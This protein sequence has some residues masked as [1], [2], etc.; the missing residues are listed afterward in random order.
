MAR[1][2]G[3]ATKKSRR[4]GVDLKGGDKNFDKR[5]YP[6]GE[7][8][9]GRVKETDYLL[10]LREKQKARF[11]YGVQEKQFRRY[12]KEAARQEG[13]T[14]ENLLV[15][16]ETRLDNIVYRGGF[17]RTRRESRQL[18]SHRHVLVNG[19]ITNIPS[20]QVSPG[21]EIVIKEKSRS[22]Q[23][24]VGSLE[25]FGGRD[26][27]GYLDTNTDEFKITV[28]DVPVRSQID[29]PVTEQLIVELYSK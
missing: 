16:L 13:L 22:A 6:P 2:T 21:D 20:Y 9:R 10:Q 27:P 25:L 5:P 15:L 12:Y 1:Y 26:I 17:A 4:L 8:G 14:G 29:C 18:V 11:W 7:H 19:A 28:R 24:I 3:P 23:A